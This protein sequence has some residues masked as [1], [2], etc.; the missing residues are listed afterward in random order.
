MEYSVTKISKC[1]QQS[2]MLLTKGKW[3]R[4]MRLVPI[5]VI[6]TKA[7][8]HITANPAMPPEKITLFFTH[9]SPNFSLLLAFCLIWHHGEANLQSKLEINCLLWLLQPYIFTHPSARSTEP[10]TKSFFEG[11]RERK[12]KEE[13]QQLVPHQ[14]SI[15]CTWKSL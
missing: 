3:K 1:H 6:I 7:T 15:G 9:L 5:C 14:I 8:I 11:G 12:R 2:I 10:G 13:S 4:R